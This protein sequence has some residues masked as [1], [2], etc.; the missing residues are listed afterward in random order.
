MSKAKRRVLALLD[1]NVGRRLTLVPLT[2]LTAFVLVVTLP[3]TIVVGGMWDIVRGKRRLPTIRLVFLLTGGF[4]IESAGIVVSFGAWLVTGFGKL[5]SEQWRWHCHRAFMGGY[6]NAV[7]TLIGRVIGTSI[8]WRDHA[9]LSAGP[10][11]LL[12]RHTSFFD[13]V[14]PATVMSRRSSL[15]AHHVVTH[16]LRYSPCIDI[17]GHRFPNRF[18][19][20]TPGEGSREL[21]HIEQIGSVL[22]HRSGAIIFPEGTF[23]NPDR[24]ARSIRRIG[25][26]DPELAARAEQL[27]H[28]LPPRASGTFALLQGAPDADVVIC[29]NTGLESF[30]SIADI[31]N[32]L[33]SD[34]PIIIETWRIP[35]SDI[36][37]T[38]EAFNA[39]L[40]DQ[41]VKIDQWVADHQP[42]H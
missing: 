19:K 20:R 5:G 2:Y 8:E 31:V 32:G 28:V 21:P 27:E 10:V 30:G 7:L 13:A 41:Y 26:R 6:T 42:P 12:A 23:R 22:D 11:V 39:W 9:D 38:E 1:K 24:F 3:V 25:R 33:W 14:I 35:R 4:L 16:G 29:A 37:E 36:P 17:V 18:I 40:F 15:L 34:R